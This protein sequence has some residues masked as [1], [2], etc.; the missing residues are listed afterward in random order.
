[1]VITRALVV[2]LLTITTGFAGEIDY[3]YNHALGTLQVLSR[4]SLNVFGVARYALNSAEILKTLQQAAGNL[5]PRG[6][7][8]ILYTPANPAI[9]L[10]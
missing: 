8:L 3:A 7:W 6:I 4:P 10:D 1:M 2:F 5:R 9:P